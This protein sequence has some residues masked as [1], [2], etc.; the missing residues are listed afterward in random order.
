MRLKLLVIAAS[1]L[2]AAPVQAEPAGHYGLGHVAKAAEIAPWNIDARADGTGLPPGHG[3]ARDGAQI[4][5]DTCAAC[6]GDK[7][8]GGL[9]DRLVGGQ[10]TLTTAKPIRTVG[11][12]W[13]YATTLFDYVNR[14]MP[15]DRPGSLSADEV[16][17]VSAYLL[18]LNNI[19][20]SDA[21]L[22]AASLTAIR[23]PNR[24]GFRQDPRPE[25]SLMHK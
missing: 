9:G 19:V 24:D 22:D 14:A 7:A 20:P 11:S 13:P 18:S 2:L 25:P 5:A 4:F 17:A 12:Y 8:Q 15:F 21:T 10:G 16:Y 23:M 6:H 3:N 1:I